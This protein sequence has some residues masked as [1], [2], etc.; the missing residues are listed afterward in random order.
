[1]VK[2]KR[3]GDCDKVRELQAD[4]AKLTTDVACLR[5]GMT[6]LARRVDGVGEEEG[7][8]VAPALATKVADALGMELASDVLYDEADALAYYREWA[9]VLALSEPLDWTSEWC[10]PEWRIGT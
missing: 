3:M 10:A 2:E 1:M 7:G 8:E 9:H 6:A 5:E 4:V